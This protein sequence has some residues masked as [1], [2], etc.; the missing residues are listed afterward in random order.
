MD[1]FNKRTITGIFF[2]IFIVGSVLVGPYAFAVLFLF[3]TI[4]GV[5]EFYK[6]LESDNIHP[7]KIRGLLAGSFLYTSIALVSLTVLN[8]KYLLINI[9]VLFYFFIHELFM[10]AEK[11][12]ANVA[13]SF[14]GILYIVLPFSL[15]NFLF[16]QGFD[17]AK[18]KPFLLISFFCILWANDTMAYIIGLLIGKHKFFERISPKKTWEG[19]IGGLVF[20]LAMAYVAFLF[21]GE[22]SLFHWLMIAL[23]IIIFGALGDLAE[24]SFKRSLKVKD[25]GSILPGHGGILDRFDSVLFSVPFVFLYLILIN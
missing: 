22:Y 13:Y 5:L 10:K 15:L 11:P 23:I 9:L 7:G 3:I 25:S 2:I 8:P 17:L 4:L 18:S 12:F 21:Y 1:N 20:G 14:L 6:M 19:S 24:S 16:Y